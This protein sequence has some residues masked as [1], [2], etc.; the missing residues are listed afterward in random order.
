[1][2]EVVTEV[3]PICIV[4][5]ALGGGEISQVPTTFIAPDEGVVNEAVYGFVENGWTEIT[6]LLNVDVAKNNPELQPLRVQLHWELGAQ[7]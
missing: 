5:F 1:M 7:V 4:A 3:V 6:A 2:T